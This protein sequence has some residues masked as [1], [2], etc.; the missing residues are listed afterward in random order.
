[1]SKIRFRM[2]PTGDAKLGSHLLRIRPYESA[3]AVGA[4]EFGMGS[5]GNGLER[6]LRHG[7][8]EMNQKNPS[9]PQCGELLP[10][11]GQ[12]TGFRRQFQ[13]DARNM[14]E[15]ATPIGSWQPRRTR[16]ARIGRW[17][18]TGSTV[19]THGKTFEKTAE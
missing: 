2:P 8:R 19:D 14:G 6:T 3:G 15:S 13:A 16:F 10:F 17:M 1:M 9:L 5:P 18:T 4:K 12:S 11:G 7:E